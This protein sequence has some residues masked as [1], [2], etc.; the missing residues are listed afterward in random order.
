MDLQKGL[1]GHW[2]TESID[3]DLV[4]D[5]SA[6]GNHADKF[7]EPIVV[8]GYI[9]DQALE[10]DDDKRI[11]VEDTSDL[12]PE[13]ITISL[14]VY[15]NELG[16]QELSRF[17]VDRWNGY[18]LHLERDYADSMQFFVYVD[19]E[20][21]STSRSNVGSA[22]EGELQHILV[23]YDAESGKLKFYVN[24]N[25]RD[26]NTVEGG[27][28]IEYDSSTDIDIGTNIRGQIED[29]RIYNRALT[30]REIKILSNLRNKRGRRA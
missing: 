6:N 20:T 23:S 22:E 13:S 14:F 26:E 24:N 29:V 8:D 30:Q 16:G 15:P 9:G 11:Y 21:E 17:L 2:T 1:I 12:R 18:R 5:S 27:G 10:F 4:R 28:P 19:G 25:L 3:N 7:N